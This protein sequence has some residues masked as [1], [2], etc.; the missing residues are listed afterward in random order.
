MDIKIGTFNL[1]NLFSRFNFKGA[2]D[3][4][5]QGDNTVHITYTF[6]DPATFRIRTFQGK[7]VTEKPNA[8][9]TAIANRILAMDVDVL[10]VQEVE[11]INTLQGFARDSLNDRY[12]FHVLI[13]GNDPRLI[14]VGI[15]SKLPI[16]AVTSWRHAIHP[17]DPT[18]TVFSRDL[19]EVEILNPQRTEKL[20]TIFNTHLKSHF[21]PFNEN[22]V[23]GAEE[24]N[25]RRRQQAEIA[26][27]IITARTRSDSR[28][29][30]VG[31]LND[32]PES[33]FLAPLVRSNTLSLVNALVNPRETRPSRPDNPNPTTTAWTH[34]FRSAGQ[35]QH[36]LFDQ[37]WL[38]P[39]LAGKQTDAVIDRR[40][41]H[42]GDGSDHDP[43]WITLAI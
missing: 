10:A 18:H 23:L 26:A 32:P 42:S 41:K 35:S 11:D 16:G 22:P 37:I 19:L 14:D 3:A 21:V 25:R 17:D 29:L 24:A 20:V 27:R 40:T 5:E 30:M 28:Y 9:R 4:L 6:N 15:L 38:S 1:N 12:P 43:A 8:E 39:A 33:E 2:I 31:D 7:L 13:E 34:R 36:Q